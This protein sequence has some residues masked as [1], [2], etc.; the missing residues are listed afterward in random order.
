MKKQLPLEGITVLELGN[1]VAAPFAGEIL[2]DL[3][4]DVIKVEKPD[5]GD[6][7]RKWAPPYWHGT[8]A[9]FQN[10]NR[11][12]RSIVVELRDPEENARL[13]AFI[14]ERVDV[15]LQNMRPGLVEELGLDGQTLRRSKPELIYANIGAFGAAGPYKDRPG[16]DPL[17]QAFGG[18]MSVT[19]EEGQP[20]V[21]VGTAIVD[22]STGMWSV[23][24]IV[25][26]LLARTR[27]GQGCVVGT[28]LYEASLGWMGHHA[29][30]YLASAK[31]P[32]RQGSGVAQ[33]VPSRC[34]ET[35]DGFIF[36]AIGND[37][38]FALFAGVLGHPEWV[39][40][41]R[42]SSNPQRV[43]NK[44]ELYRMIEEVVSKLTTAQLQ[45]ALDAASVPNAPMQSIDQALAHEQTK[46]LGILQESPDGKIALIGSPLSLDGVRL[47]FRRSPPAL[48]AQTAEILGTDAKR[49][50][51]SDT[52]MPQKA[53]A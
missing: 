20:P 42:F 50:T 29:A 1:S 21:R 48:G 17:M 33:V 6:D 47:P 25:S 30:D 12:K 26:A 15:V 41:P 38:L 8:S 44:V 49:A 23:I 10:F 19:G 13:R 7:A 4:A 35:G 52:T 39:Q 2:G 51:K 9:I 53:Q 3:G 14:L 27:N 24:G 18:L 43:H 31:V 40:D 46:A 34:Y 11:N 45:Q 16:Y 28:S 37:K 32:Q 36:I 22:M 5:G